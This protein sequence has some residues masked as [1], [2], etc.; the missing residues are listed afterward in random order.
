LIAFD[1]NILIRLLVQ[2]DPKQAAEA[3]R[4]LH[5]AA[6]AGETV[7]LCVPVLCEVV[8]VLRSQYKASRAEAAEALESFLH[9]ELFDFEDRG[10]VASALDAYRRTKADFAD[11]LI[12]FTARTR[13]ARTTY[14]FDGALASQL[15]FS[16][17]PAAG[18]PTSAS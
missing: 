5:E 8:W 4:L 16:V 10:V 17:L 9:N 18:A 11:F 6:A 13:G 15:G 2:D 7:L 12:G 1:T 14:S 3:E